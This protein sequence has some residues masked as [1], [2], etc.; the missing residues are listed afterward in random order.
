LEEDGTGPVSDLL[1]AQTNL[2]HV[3]KT[4]NSCKN[5]RQIVKYNLRISVNKTKCNGYERKDE[6]ENKNSDK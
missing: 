5:E 4:A 1:L 3:T 2:G 6:Y